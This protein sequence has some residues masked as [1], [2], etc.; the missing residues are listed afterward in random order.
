M[1]RGAAK[2]RAAPGGGGAGATATPSLARRSSSRPRGSF[3]PAALGVAGEG[4][5]LV[6]LLDVVPE[7]PEGGCRLDLWDLTRPA[8]TA[9]AP[10]PGPCPVRV[11]LAGRKVW[12]YEASNRVSLVAEAF[13]APPPCP[14]SP[15]PPI[16]H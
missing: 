12:L 13:H 7:Q 6:V 9:V 4:S 11:A 2:R 10:L 3:F 5:Q 15:P 14:L 8:L 16:A 1:A